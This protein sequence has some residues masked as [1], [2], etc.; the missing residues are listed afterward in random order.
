MPYLGCGCADRAIG[1]TVVDDNLV[2]GL[3]DLFAVLPGY[4]ATGEDNIGFPALALF[5]QFPFVSWLQYRI[6]RTIDKLC[7]ISQIQEHHT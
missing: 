4:S 3:E 2:P 5:P 6:W 1:G 7:R